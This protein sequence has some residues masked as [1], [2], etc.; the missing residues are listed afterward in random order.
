MMMA[1]LN[2]SSTLPG[3][4]EPGGGG[5]GQAGWG[6]QAAR[7]GSGPQQL[8]QAGRAGCGPQLQQLLLDQ[9]KVIQVNLA[10]SFWKGVGDIKVSSYLTLSFVGFI[11]I[12]RPWKTLSLVFIGDIST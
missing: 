10:R 11:L 4:G 5:P 9:N 6:G 8:G 1:C 2:K 3:A 7:A 12:R